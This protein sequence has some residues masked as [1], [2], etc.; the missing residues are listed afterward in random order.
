MDRQIVYPGAIPLETDLLNTN[1]N[2]MIGLAKLAAAI[3]GTG[4]MLNGL[5]CTPDSPASLNV[6]VAAGEIYSLQNIDGTAYS[7]LAAETAHSI[8]KQGIMLDSVLLPCPAPET[9][10]YSIN[11]LVQ[12]AYQ[13]TDANAVVLPY[14]NA[15]N[16]PQAYS[17][18]N[19]SGATNYTTRKGVCA[20]SVKAGVAAATGTQTTPA[21]DAGYTGIY[22]VTAACGQTQITAGN[23]NAISGAP[24]INSTLLGLSPAFAVSPTAPTPPQSDNGAKVATTAF[25]QQAVGN[26][27]GQVAFFAFPYAPDGWLKCNGAAVSRT[28]YAELF[29]IIGT[30]FGAGSG[31]FNLPDLRGEFVRGFDDGRD[32]DK[33]RSFGSQQAASKVLGAT[34]NP[35]LPYLNRNG[36]HYSIDNG[37]TLRKISDSNIEQ[38][39][40]T[41]ENTEQ[42]LGGTYSYNTATYGSCAGAPMTQ[43][44]Y[45]YH[46]ETGELVSCSEADPSPLEPGVFLIPALATDIAPPDTGKGQVAVFSKGKWTVKTIPVPSPSELLARARQGQLAAIVSACQSAIVAGFSSS[47]LGTA[48]LYPS[49][50]TDQRNLLSIV[51][52][53]QGQNA[54]WTVPL[55][56][57]ADG[58]GLFVPHTAAQVR[59]VNTDWVAFRTERQ[60]KGGGSRVV[61]M[62][63]A[64]SAAAASQIGKPYD[65]TA[66]LGLGLRRDWQQDDAWF[67]SESVAWAFDSAGHPLF[68]PDSLRRVTPQ[69]LWML[70]PSPP[71]EQPAAETLPIGRLARP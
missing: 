26:I 64:E 45:N 13:D 5:A 54:Q 19:N 65:Y 41:Y 21:P 7:S 70:A 36:W 15:G 47:A 10:G 39:I 32:V 57:T 22:S 27:T 61:T 18:P 51:L 16:P 40:T 12:V 43:T 67:C 46:P 11:Y 53:A 9:N 29:A 23:I 38:P 42:F 59:Q 48:Y 3:M 37:A 14:Y 17:G 30:T 71:V 8:L 28:R 50:D 69:H 4:T 68:R 60:R 25:V 44:V 52:A 63:E 55:W 58:K 31:T 24:F 1:K 49:A 2:A 62:P 6:K 33:M 20:V 56:C 35:S 34:G 66:I